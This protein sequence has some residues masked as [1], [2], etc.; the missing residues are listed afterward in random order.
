MLLETARLLWK[1]RNEQWLSPE[2]L[3]D[4]RQKRLREIVHH[5]YNNTRFYRDLFTKNGIAPS[6]IKTKEDLTLLPPT[7]KSDLQDR[8]QDL[9]AVGYSPENCYVYHTSGST[10]TPATMLY[11]SFAKA[12]TGAEDYV[13]MFDVGYKPWE[14]IA[15]TKRTPWT[16]HPLQ[17][18]GIMRACHIL[19]SLPEEEQ[20]RLLQKVNP[21]LV[22]SYPL[23]LH[24]IARA[25]RNE[26]CNIH[27]KAAIVGGELLTPQVR[28]FIEEV[29]ST[30]IF[31]TYATVE[32]ATIAKECSLHNWHIHSTRCLV[33]FVDGRILVSGLINKALPLLRYEIGDRGAPKE[34]VCPCGRGYP[35]MQILEGRSGDLFILPNGRE[36]PPLRVFK[37][38]LILDSNEA[39][40]RYQ[41]IQ[42]DY[43]HFTIR[44]V[45]TPAFTD[46]I[47]Q[48]LKAQLVEDLQYP[49]T[50]DI[51]E[52]DTIPLIDDRKLRVNIS[53]VRKKCCEDS[54]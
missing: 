34:G 30:S 22:V 52:V 4:I 12:Y 18:L 39:A 27:P 25:A 15:Y 2:I 42:E 13:F 26:G 19:S 20:A 11:D 36:I 23:L 21:S 54:G 31:E 51:E 29:L 1:I 41:I 47:A 10:G 28:A 16:S 43:D 50:V 46:V 44:V 40:K 33:E 45:P 8:F 24:S 37:T 7:T 9:V 32:F 5:A 53:R 38:R 48:Q 35:M 17:A 49:A 6:D 14:K 3:D